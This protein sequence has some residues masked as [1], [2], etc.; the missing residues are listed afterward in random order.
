[1]TQQLSLSARP[2]SLDA[3]I[4]RRRLAKRIRGH[5]ASGRVTKVWQFV[6]SKGSGKTTVARILSL[7]Y[8]CS[9]GIFGQPCA[10]CRKN[11][12]NFDIHYVNAA[13]ITGIRDLESALE[14]AYFAPRMGPYR[15]YILDECHRFTSQAQGLLLGY[16]ED[17]TPETTIFIL[18]TTDPHLILATIQSRC[19]T[20]KLDDLQEEEI[21]KL[22]PMLLEQAES[23]LPADRLVMALAEHSIG[24]PRLIAQAVEKYIAGA[25][26][27]EACYVEASSDVDTRALTKAVVRGDWPAAAK[28]LED[29]QFSDVEGVRLG[30][31]AYMRKMLL[32]SSEISERTG[33]IA[34]AVESLVDVPQGAESVRAA[35][36]TAAMYRATSVLAKYKG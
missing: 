10:A 18:C 31:M 14:G 32:H 15:I 25:P 33:A 35:A 11:R 3:M 17:D 12:S 36:L 1:M 6:G 19:T 26:P 5:M 21:A 27:E 34:R 28:Y 7:S 22:V 24:S 2:K 13:K 4:G 9:H 29:M 30:S 8:Q 20:Y 16:L 23:E